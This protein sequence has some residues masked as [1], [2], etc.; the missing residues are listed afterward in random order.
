MKRYVVILSLVILLLT[1]LVPSGAL[2]QTPAANHVYLSTQTLYVN[3]EPIQPFDMYNIDGYNY[4][5]LRDIAYLLKD[6]YAGFSIG[7]DAQSQT[8]TAISGQPY[9]PEGNELTRGKDNS[10]SC[11]PSPHTVLFNGTPSTAYAYNIGGNNYFKLRDIAEAFN[12]YVDYLESTKTL[13]I[14]AQ[15]KENTTSPSVGANVQQNDE[16][17]LFAYL[18]KCAEIADDLLDLAKEI[19]QTIGETNN[20]YNK[21]LSISNELDRISDEADHMNQTLLPRNNTDAN[22]MNSI[23]YDFHGETCKLLTDFLVYENDPTSANLF[24]YNNQLREVSSGY[25]EVFR[26]INKF[27]YKSFK[28]SYLSPHYASNFTPSIT[29]P[30]IEIPSST[31]PIIGFPGTAGSS[32]EEELESIEDYYGTKIKALSRERERAYQNALAISAAGTG[33][34]PSSA[35]YTQAA[36]AAAPYDREIAALRAEKAAEIERLKQKYDIR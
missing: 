2:A 15:A 8:A 17:A 23:L 31:N 28:S 34:I 10:S 14:N 21:A 13:R 18:E 6:T 22:E 20:L 3:G 30:D 9:I 33:G 35:A 26:F 24:T 19:T 4:F 5:K 11:R 1:A 27:F 7:Y 32:Y 25:Q 16:E 29:F 12:F 36:A